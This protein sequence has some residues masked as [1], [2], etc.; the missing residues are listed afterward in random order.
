MSQATERPINFFL[1][2]QELLAIGSSFQFKNW[3]SETFTVTPKNLVE[4]RKKRQ[5][6]IN[7]DHFV[8]VGALNG[9]IPL[10]EIMKE[11]ERIGEV[12][13]F[14]AFALFD[15]KAQDLYFGDD[16]GGR[17]GF[18]PWFKLNTIDSRDGF[19]DRTLHFRLKNENASISATEDELKML[20]VAKDIDQIYLSEYN[21][22]LQTMDLS[23]NPQAMHE[24]VAYYLT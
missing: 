11:R 7:E 12:G 3:K 17:S 9:K 15:I 6:Y 22:I 23:A 1:T 18:S 13:G 19:G 2:P 21:S 14:T 5:F 8:P 16:N 24:D 10:D 4:L 20:R